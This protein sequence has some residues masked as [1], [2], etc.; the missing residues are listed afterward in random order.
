MTAATDG[1]TPK[2]ATKLAPLDAPL[3]T[4]VEA[5]F[6]VGELWTDATVL[7]DWQCAVECCRRHDLEYVVHFP[8][9]KDIGVESLPHA[10]ELCRALRSPV[11]VVHQFAFD[12]FGAQLNQLDPSLL[13]AVENH[14]LPPPAFDQWAERNPGLTLD[15]EHVWE[16]TL[17]NPPLPDVLAFVDRFLARFAG[18]LLHVHMPGYEPGG[19]QH[20]PIHHSPVL[21]SAVLTRLADAG[22]RG[23]VVS[24][25]ALEYQRLDELR[26]DVE[27]FEA[28]KRN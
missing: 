6:H 8:T 14:R 1:S 5:G 13:L 3:A 19:A 15:I 28:W 20:R 26:R 18:K 17:Q 27:F 11:M 4:A 12:K 25:V 9:R 10:V 24:E 16:M 2:L 21:A 7:A 23:V 22:F